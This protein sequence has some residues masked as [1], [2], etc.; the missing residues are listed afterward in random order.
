[1]KPKRAS[2]DPD[3]RVKKE[4]DPEVALRALLQVDPDPSPSRRQAI[5]DAPG[6][7]DPSHGPCGELR[8]RGRRACLR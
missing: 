1:M 6:G 3:E 8:A 4:L 7:A 5:V 2:A